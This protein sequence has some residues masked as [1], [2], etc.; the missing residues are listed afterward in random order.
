[1]LTTAILGFI[2]SQ[3]TTSDETLPHNSKSN[4]K[5]RSRPWPEFSWK[6]GG[7]KTFEHPTRTFELRVRQFFVSL[8]RCPFPTLG[9]RVQFAASDQLGVSSTLSA[10][11]RKMFLERSAPEVPS[12]CDSYIY[13]SIFRCH[14]PAFLE[15]TNVLLRTGKRVQATD[16]IR[17]THVSAQQGAFKSPRPTITSTVRSHN[18]LKDT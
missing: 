15:C 8:N 3:K 12:R 7:F 5:A 4:I 18:L 9:Y 2:S 17:F 1:M 11:A 16:L 10:K 6:K 14:G 13:I